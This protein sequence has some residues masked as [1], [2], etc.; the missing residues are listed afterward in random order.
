MKAEKKSVISDPQPTIYGFGKAY[1]ERSFNSAPLPEFSGALSGGKAIVDLLVG[2]SCGYREAM[3]RAA[4]PIPEP[5]KLRALI[6]TGFTGGLA[7]DQ[8]SIKGLR[9]QFRNFNR[10]SLPSI[11]SR[12]FET[13]EW[14]VDVSMRLV[15]SESK[16]TDIVIDPIAAT[17][18]E[19]VPEMHGIQALIGQEILQVCILTIDGRRGVFKLTF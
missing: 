3:Q 1:G 16:G 15:A 11:S 13:Y 12:F 8:D 18:L 10:V 19:L 4:M 5:V 17:V 14:E 7:V 6:D 9:L 2:V